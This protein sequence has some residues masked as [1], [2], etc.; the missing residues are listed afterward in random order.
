MDGQGKQTFSAASMDDQAK[1]AFSAASDWSKQIMTLSTGIVTLT[2]TFSDKVFGNL[3]HTETWLLMIAWALYIISILGGIWVL[4]ALN[5]KLVLDKPPVAADVLSAHFRAGVQATT[6][7][8]ATVV[9]AIFGFLTVSND[10][11]SPPA[12][13]GSVAD[14]AAP[15]GSCHQP[16][17]AAHEST[18]AVTRLAAICGLAFALIP[19]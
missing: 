1:Q 13:S 17:V 12:T 18:P 16:G 6:F 9:I 7:V 11:S 19:A 4:T 2:V 3:S 8:A 10:G 5:D 14:L 15:K